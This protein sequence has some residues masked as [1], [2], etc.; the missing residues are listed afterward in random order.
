MA[1]SNKNSLDKRSKDLRDKHLMTFD[2]D[3]ISRVELTAPEADHRVRQGRPERMADPEAEADARGRLPG[4]G[5][6]SQAEGREHGH[7]RIGR[8]CQESRRGVR[9]GHAGSRSRR[10]PTPNGTQTL[11]VRKIQGRLLRQIERGGRRPQ[12]HQGRRRRPGQSARRFPQQEAVRL[13]LQRS[14]AHRD[15]GRRR[16]ARCIEKSGDKWTSGGKTMDSTSVQEFIDKLRDL[17]AAKFVDSGFTTPALELTVVSNDGKRTEKVQIAP[18]PARTSW[19]GAKATRSLYQLDANAVNG[20]APGGWRRK[21]TA[22][23][24][25]TRRRNSGP[26]RPPHRSL[27][28]HHGGRL[29]RGRKDAASAPPSSCSCGACRTIATSFSPPGWRRPSSTCWIC[30]FTAEE[31]AYLRGLPQFA[32]TRPEFFEMLGGLALHRRLVRGARRHAAVRGR[33][34][35]DACARPLIEAQ[36]PETYLLAIIGFQSMIA[37]K[38]ARVVKAAAGTRRGRVRNPPRAFARSR[39]AGGTR[40]LHRRLRRHQQRGNRIALRRSGIRHGG[41]FLGDVVSQRAGG[42][43][44]ACSNCWAKAPST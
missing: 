38:A 43:R 7:Q 19:R 17:A 24:A 20:S 15:Q 26:S 41:A 21:A 11:E 2:Q 29:L 27:S 22:P 44:A 3:K 8:R 1:S 18:L 36:I 13:R 39:R 31:I 33:A 4:G 35:S 10:S 25:E 34:V 6:G 42:V 40:G 12:G 14:H 32:R 23:A 37:T 5:P 28:A 9:V 30:S 16:R